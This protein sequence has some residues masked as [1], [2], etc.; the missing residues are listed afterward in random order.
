MSGHITTRPTANMLAYL[1]WMGRGATVTGS[2]LGDGR[3]WTAGGPERVPARTMQ[4]LIRRGLIA[5]EPDSRIA[6]T[7]CWHWCL[8]QR[9]LEVLA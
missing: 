1:R 2:G 4:G 8:T 7:L 9:G 3:L 6:D 5:R